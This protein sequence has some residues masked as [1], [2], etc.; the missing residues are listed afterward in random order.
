MNIDYIITTPEGIIVGLFVLP[1]MLGWLG[2]CLM[3][4]AEIFIEVRLILRGIPFE[5]RVKRHRVLKDNIQRESLNE[6]VMENAE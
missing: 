2:A 5:E 3:A 4:V 1:F 6:G